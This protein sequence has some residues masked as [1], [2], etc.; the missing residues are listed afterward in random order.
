MPR[1]ISAFFLCLLSLLLLN[2]RPGHAQAVAPVQRHTFT[3]SA[4]LM[5]SHFTFT[6]V[7]ADDSAG[8]RALRAGL[9]EVRRIDRLMSFWDSTSRGGAREPGGGLAPGGGIGRNV[10]FD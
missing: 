3:R 9:G 5:G 10:R 7:A 8:Q 4:H 6:V 2:S 1:R